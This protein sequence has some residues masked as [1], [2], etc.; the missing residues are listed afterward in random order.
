MQTATT[1]QCLAFKIDIGVLYPVIRA[2][3][4]FFRSTQGLYV[5]D[6]R[7]GPGLLR[8][9]DGTTDLGVWN[10]PRIVRLLRDP[11]TW[12]NAPPT[13][14]QPHQPPAQA[15]E[16]QASL[17]SQS[18]TALPAGGE[19]QQQRQQRSEKNTSKT[20][21]ASSPVS[22]TAPIPLLILLMGV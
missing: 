22:N 14:Q 16:S 19:H 6:E 20:P 11:V 21:S 7:V 12:S 2:D 9:T 1:T 4:V 5:Q 18:S 10:G 13:Q 17:K 3:L 15:D 8:Y